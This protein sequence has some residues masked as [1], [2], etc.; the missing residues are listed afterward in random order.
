MK[1][2]WEFQ[3]EAG[4]TGRGLALKHCSG[5]VLIWVVWVEHSDA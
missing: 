5:R 3:K 4:C 2:Q 1:M